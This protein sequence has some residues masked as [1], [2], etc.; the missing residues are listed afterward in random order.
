MS[1]CWENWEKA[2]KEKS[3]LYHFLF[4][5]IVYIH[6]YT[7]KYIANYNKLFSTQLWYVNAKKIKIKYLFFQDKVF[8][9]LLKWPKKY[10]K[11]VVI[12]ALYRYILHV[13]DI[14]DIEVI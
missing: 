13:Y 5:L 3:Y 11:R 9:E 7:R 6:T 8:E 2:L 4:S 14:R 12:T 10:G 1:H